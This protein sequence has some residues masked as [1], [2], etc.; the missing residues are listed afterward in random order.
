MKNFTCFANINNLKAQKIGEIL[1]VVSYN[2]GPD[3]NCKNPFLP[4]YF[5]YQNN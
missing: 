4:K 1:K 3:E 5:T 2:R